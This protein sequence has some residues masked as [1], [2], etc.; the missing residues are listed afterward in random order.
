MVRTY[1]PKT[2]RRS[3]DEER[4]KTT[5]SDVTLKVLSIRKAAE[6]YGIKPATLQYR[7]EKF[8]KA[9]EEG[10]RHLLICIGQNI[11][12]QVFTVDQE[13]MFSE[14][15]LTCSKMHYGLTLQQLL[16]LAYEYAEHL[17]CKYPESWRK[18]KRAGKDWAA[19][20]RNRN[21]ELSL[22]KP[23]NTTPQEVLHLIRLQW[24]NF[25]I[26]LSV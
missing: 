12:A 19:G 13:K 15:L 25:L 20:F 26:I 22:R 10:N 16:T 9:S 1:K 23:E 2:E 17:G 6:K 5:V 18:N 11:L 21:Q 8:G 24:L 7:V 3:L 4:I 14:Y